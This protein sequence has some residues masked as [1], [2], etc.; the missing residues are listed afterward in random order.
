MEGKEGAFSVTFITG[1]SFFFL[2]GTGGKEEI[3]SMTSL[4]WK[5]FPPMVISCISFFKAGSFQENLK[6]QKLQQWTDVVLHSF[7]VLPVFPS[8]IRYSCIGFF[9]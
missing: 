4:D 7:C 8:F 9:F 6:L 2:G 1:V 5:L 3:Q